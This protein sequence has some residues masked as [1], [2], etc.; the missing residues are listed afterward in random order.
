[1]WTA[2]GGAFDMGARLDKFAKGNAFTNSI[3]NRPTLFPMADGMGLMGEAGPEAVLPLTR[4]PNGDLGV[5]MPGAPPAAA[6]PNIT[7]NIDARGADREGLNRLTAAIRQLDGKVNYLDRTMDRRAV[8][9]MAYARSRGGNIARAF[10]G[11]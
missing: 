3:V 5:S 11:W 4:L 1:M 9:A 6:G 10:G 2:K 7:Y 8:N